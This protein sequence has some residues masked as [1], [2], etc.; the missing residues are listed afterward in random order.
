MPLAPAPFGFTSASAEATMAGEIRYSL[1]DMIH[2]P[3][4]PLGPRPTLPRSSCL[5]LRV[6]TGAAE[7][8]AKQSAA[9]SSSPSWLLQ[10]TCSCFSAIAAGK[11]RLPRASLW[12]RSRPSPWG[13]PLLRTR[14]FC[15]GERLRLTVSA[16]D[17]CK[18]LIQIL[19]KRLIVQGR[20][21]HE[22]REN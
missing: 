15:R 12:R 7:Q 21:F 1:S 19:N 10:D 3:R 2:L 5:H 13:W 16:R 17:R 22:Q 9:P 20:I 4:P 11:Q 6:V 14:G 18:M 8:L